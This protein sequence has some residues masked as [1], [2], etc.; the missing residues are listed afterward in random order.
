MTPDPIIVETL[1]RM[2]EDHCSATVVQEAEAGQWLEGLWS[3]LE[4]T[5]L[6]LTWVPEEHAGAGASLIDG[7]EVAKVAGRYAVPVP[8]VETLL[9]GWVLSQAN[10]KAPSGPL[11]VAPARAEDCV[12]AER[13]GTLSGEAHRVPYARSAE[14]LVVITPEAVALVETK[15]LDIVSRDGISGEPRDSVRF[16]QTPVS[17]W[18]T[19]ESN[20]ERSV[21]LMGAVLRTLQMAGALERV[22]A[23]STQYA[24]ERSQFGRPIAKFQAVQHNL[25]VLAGE[26][27][28]AGAAANT[29][30]RVVTRHGLEDDR[31]RLAVASAKVR[32]GEAA[33]TG[34]AIAHQVHGAMGFTREYRLHHFTRRLL[35]WRDDFGS[36]NRWARELGRYVAEEGADALWPSLTSI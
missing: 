4:T 18:S 31:S 12:K 7:F 21:Q 30:A 10:V 11:S 34:A 29:A 25:A 36:E 17:A 19:V 27:A 20:L 22:L 23:L 1:E 35:S 9:A 13:G 5:G 28:A 24:G 3:Q 33:G 15:C 6:T 14:H 32:A 8:L 16:D 2:L 26:M